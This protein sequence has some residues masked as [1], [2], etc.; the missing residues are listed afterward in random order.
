MTLLGFVH[1][2]HLTPRCPGYPWP[3]PDFLQPVYL[4]RADAFLPDAMRP[5]EDESDAYTFHPMT[6][7]LTLAVPAVEQCF[8]D[9]VVH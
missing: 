9:A 2:H 7:V 4:A 1:F 6:E 3:H 8:L 5:H